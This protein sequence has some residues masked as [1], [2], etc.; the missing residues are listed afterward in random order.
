MKTKRDTNMAMTTITIP[1]DSELARIYNTASVE[2]QRKLQAFFVMFL[3]FMATEATSDQLDLK[4][5][6]DRISDRAQAR[7]LTPD[8]LESLLGDDE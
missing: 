2:D 8:I 6:M 5:L 3:R 1:V 4:T 7:G